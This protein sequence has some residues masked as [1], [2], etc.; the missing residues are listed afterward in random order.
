MACDRN[1]ASIYRKH[2]LTLT[3]LGFMFLLVISAHIAF[4]SEPPRIVLTMFIPCHACPSLKLANAVRA[5]SDRWIG[6]SI[7]QIKQR[8]ELGFWKVN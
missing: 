6:S 7:S 1:M 5:R 3:V 2:L 8:R 4:V